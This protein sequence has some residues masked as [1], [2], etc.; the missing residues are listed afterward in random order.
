MAAHTCVRI[1]LMVRKIS[2]VGGKAQ[3]RL[4]LHMRTFMIVCVFSAGVNI[5][6]GFKPKT[7]VCEVG[8]CFDFFF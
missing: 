4:L 5:L 7:L 8:Q 6:C 3:E 1:L 2:W